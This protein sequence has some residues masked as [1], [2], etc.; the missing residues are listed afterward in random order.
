M[1]QPSAEVLL[2]QIT[3]LPPDERA[4]LELL[5]EEERRARQLASVRPPR[6]QRL[7][8]QPMPDSRREIEWL[9]DH[10]REFAGQWV[11][12]D[13]DRLIAHG[14][15]YRTVFAAADADAAP[16]PLITFVEDP[17]H[18]IHIIWK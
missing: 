12:L 6:D 15:D 7:P 1:S 13:G 11:A 4:R 3:A 5:L 9:A 16:L 14:P 8:P 10:A 17:D 2:Q 18:P